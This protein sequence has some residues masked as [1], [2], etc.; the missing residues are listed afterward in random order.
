MSQPQK[1]KVSTKSLHEK[2]KA[3]KKIENS[4]SKNEAASKYNV[5][6]NIISTWLKNEKI[7]STVTKGK[8]PKT[9]NLKGGSYVM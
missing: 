7:I 3:L 4:L 5:S 8:T 1:R 2:Y 6:L 9:K